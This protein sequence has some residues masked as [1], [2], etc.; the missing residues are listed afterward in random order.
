[1]RRALKLI[2]D[3]GTYLP[4][5]AKMSQEKLARLFANTAFFLQGQMDIHP[6]SRWHDPAFVARTGGF[7]LPGDPVARRIM[8]L[9][10]WDHVRRDML[11]LLLRS[12]NERRVPGAM[13]ELGV[14]RG[15]TA[16]LLHHYMP[17]RALHL[18]D[19]FS[20]FDAGEVAS[21]RSRTGHAVEAGRYGGTSPAEVLATIAPQ[22]ERVRLHPGLFPASVPPELERE[23]FAFVHLDADLHDPTRAGLEFFWER[24]A[25]GGFVVVHDYNAW[26]GARAAVDGFLAGRR[27]VAIPMPDKSGSALIVRQG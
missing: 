20:G 21:E 23:T 18:F 13:A 24:V 11:A 27:E 12:L 9:E 4:L 10:P 15:S 6:R 22:N 19:T 7:F 1:M 17:D 25:P 5:A 8:D 26:P 2:R 3:P 14:F 16:R